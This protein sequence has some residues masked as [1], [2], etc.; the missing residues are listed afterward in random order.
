MRR[1]QSRIL[2]EEK[3]NLGSWLF[4]NLYCTSGKLADPFIEVF[5]L[6]ALKLEISTNTPDLA[7]LDLL[8]SAHVLQ[9]GFDF[10]SGTGLCWY[11]QLKPR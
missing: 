1:D 6:L 3:R 9:F 11:L 4:L 2:V 5:Q 7:T 8:L 10:V